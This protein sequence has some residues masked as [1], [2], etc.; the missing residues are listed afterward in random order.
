MCKL[1]FSVTSN[2]IVEYTVY[3]H[4]ATQKVPSRDHF[5]TDLDVGTVTNS[6][7]QSERKQKK[8]KSW[9]ISKVH[10]FGIQWGWQKHS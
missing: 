8:E 9:H 7:R 1:Q 10:R 5:T 4:K 3:Y 2:L 6:G